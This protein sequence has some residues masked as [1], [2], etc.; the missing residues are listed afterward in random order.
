MVDIHDYPFSI[1]LGHSQNHLAVAGRYVVDA[2]GKQ[3]GYAPTRYREVVLTVSKCKFLFLR[4]AFKGG[5]VERDR[6]GARQTE[7]I[8]SGRIQLQRDTG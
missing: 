2:L 3:C 1:L 7:K 6:T 4:I 8:L 5:V